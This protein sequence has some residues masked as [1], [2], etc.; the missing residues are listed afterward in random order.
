[1]INTTKT[2]PAIET[3]MNVVLDMDGSSPSSAFT[4]VSSTTS[5]LFNGS[6]ADRSVGVVDCV[7]DCEVDGIA[8]AGDDGVV[9]IGGCGGE[10]VADEGGD[11]GGVDEGSGEDDRA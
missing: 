7:V 6:F 11:D 4:S 1:M 8:F 2:P 10:V 5:S 3:M 9:A